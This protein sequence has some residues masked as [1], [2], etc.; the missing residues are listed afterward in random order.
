LLA[1]V[2]PDFLAIKMKRKRQTQPEKRSSKPRGRAKLLPTSEE[3]K[4]RSAIL[5]KRS[6]SLILKFNPMPL[7]LLK[8]AKTD[9]RVDTNTRIPSKGRFSFELN[10]DADLRDALLWLDHAYRAVA[11]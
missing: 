8:R 3:M 4:Q 6:S 5:V 11:K 9:P 10:S 2:N 7:A 1:P